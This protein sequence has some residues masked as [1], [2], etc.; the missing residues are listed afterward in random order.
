[1]ELHQS[2]NEENKENLMSTMERGRGSVIYSRMVETRTF[3][4]GTQ[5]HVEGLAGYV[6]AF[7]AENGGL[8][9]EHGREWTVELCAE[10]LKIPGPTLRRWVGTPDDQQEPAPF[11]PEDRSVWGEFP[12]PGCIHRNRRRSGEG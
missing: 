3:L 5:A 4:S 6:R 8:T 1:M 11:L 10:L 9:N 2:A 12:E 7:L